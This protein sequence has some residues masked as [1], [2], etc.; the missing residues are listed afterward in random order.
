MDR[1][2]RTGFVPIVSIG[3]GK[4]VVGRKGRSRVLVLSLWRPFLPCGGR[5]CVVERLLS[6][7]VA[8]D[9]YLYPWTYTYKRKC[10]RGF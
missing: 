3:Q 5:S 6:L 4:D 8:V 10:K 9:K 7:N 1:S 2:G